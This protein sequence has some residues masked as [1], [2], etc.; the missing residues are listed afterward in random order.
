MK[1]LKNNFCEIILTIMA[2]VVP[3]IGI[4]EKINIFEQNIIRRNFLFIIGIFLIIALIIKRKKLKYDKKDSLLLIFFL[5][6]VISTIFSIYR[7]RAIFGQPNR[8]EGI[9]MIGIY[10]LIYYSAKYL[11]N[12][13]KKF[14][15]L[16]CVMAVALTILAILQFYNMVPILKNIYQIPA[17]NSTF[18]NSN[19]FANFISIF[20]PMMLGIYIIKGGKGSICCSL[21]FLTG[22]LISLARSAYISFFVYY[23][24]TFIYIIKNKEKEYIKRF[25]IITVSF[26][27]LCG[28]V[29]YTSN[30]RVAGR[31]ELIVKEAQ[32][33][34]DGITDQMGSGRIFYW[35][36]VAMLM[37]ERPILGYGPD[38]IKYAIKWVHPDIF[39]QFHI[40][41]GGVVIEKAHNEWLQ[42]GATMG[43]PAMLIY[44]LFIILVLK[45]NLKNMMNNKV[46]FIF[47]IMIIGYLVQAFFNISVI[48]VAPLFWLVLGLS[49]NENFKTKCL[50]ELNKKDIANS[51]ISK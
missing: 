45:N 8:H 9:L 2:I 19:I 30:N 26:I 27:I 31:G 22:M 39:K 24:L 13:Y 1:I 51:T 10:I 46:C 17:P 32:S 40:K 4:P 11:F 7:N 33:M 50:E 14:I 6:G 37:L 5:I 15:P 21:I 18:N 48:S 36:T 12:Y 41:T 25:A 29:N 16:L 28:L 23:V 44:T 20:V 3:V 42:I 47:S 35:K 43:I 49:E 34:K 38:T